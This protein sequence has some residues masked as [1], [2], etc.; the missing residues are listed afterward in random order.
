M[1][2]FWDVVS[3]VAVV[4]V[5]AAA[6]FVAWLWRN[7]RL[8]VDRLEAIRTLLAVTV[9]DAAATDA[10]LA[11]EEDA[12]VQAAAAERLRQHPPLPS[13]AQVALDYL[14][15]ERIREA[16]RRVREETMQLQAS[17]DLRT[18][19]LDGLEQDLR[20]REA[21][22]NASISEE[23]QRRVDEQFQK[24]LSLEPQNQDALYNLNKLG[25]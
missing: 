8:D 7:D 10:A 18:R 4:N 17:L 14:V 3:F 13:D 6:G 1:K 23:L 21:S 12:I 5:L 9:S 16:N 11:A 2:R 25:A 15:N 20:D 19:Q 22:W 24:A